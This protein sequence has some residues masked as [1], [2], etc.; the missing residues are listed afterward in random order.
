MA[1]KPPE[2]RFVVTCELTG[3]EHSALKSLLKKRNERAV[4]LCHPKVYI[5]DFVRGVVVAAIRGKAARA[6]R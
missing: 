1:I 4:A 5:K 3:E 2:G 6:A